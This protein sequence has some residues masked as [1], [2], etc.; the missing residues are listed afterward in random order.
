MMKIA[1]CHFDAASAKRNE[2]ERLDRNTDVLGEDIR[3]R[4]CEPFRYLQGGEFGGLALIETDKELA[5]VR[6]ETC[7]ECGRPAGKYQ[8]S[9]SFTSAM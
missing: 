5:A 6:A 9:P 3:R 1:D 7:S 4:M 8:R 2:N